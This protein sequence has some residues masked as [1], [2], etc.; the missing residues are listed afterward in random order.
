M[1]TPPVHPSHGRRPR[2]TSRRR[3][4]PS[5]RSRTML[6]CR[7]T[8]PKE[9]SR[10]VAAEEERAHFRV[11]TKPSDKMVGFAKMVAEVDLKEGESGFAKMIA[12]DSSDEELGPDHIYAAQASCFRDT[13]N[14]LYSRYF[15]HFED[16]IMYTETLPTETTDCPSSPPPGVPKACTGDEAGNGVVCA[17]LCLY[18]PR[19]KKQ[20]V[21]SARKALILRHWWPWSSS[22]DVDAARSWSP[23]V[24]EGSASFKHWNGSQFSRIMPREAAEHAEAGAESKNR[25]S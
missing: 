2:R 10:K 11:E 13:W 7:P 1:G 15:G 16:T 22:R 14:A 24:G 23:D 21:E 17:A 9:P 8:T 4:P 25:G 5:T 6:A 20:L 18:L 19:R 3:V 12:E